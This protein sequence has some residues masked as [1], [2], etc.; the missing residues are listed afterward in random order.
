MIVGN[1]QSSDTHAYCEQEEGIKKDQMKKIY[2]GLL[3]LLIIGAIGFIGCR[4]E[5]A[6]QAAA[7]AV[8]VT[9]EALAK[10]AG[11]IAFN[12]GSNRFD[13]VYL[14]YTY[15]DKRKK[16]EIITQSDRLL[17]RLRKEPENPSLQQELAEF[18]HFKDMTALKEHTQAII[19]NI[20]KM[21]SR[22]G[23]RNTFLSP[24]G[25]RLFY[26]ARTLYAG[27][28]LKEAKTKTNGIW[29]EFVEGNLSSFDYYDYVN[30]EGLEAFDEQGGSSCS[31]VCCWE[32]LSCEANAHSNFIRNSWAYALGG[33]GAMATG[34]AAAGSGVP[35]I[36]T[37]A[38]GLV[39]G[40]WGASMGL[41]AANTIYKNDLYTCK[42]NYIICL[43]KKNK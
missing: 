35:G 6:H 7:G 13:P 2:S 8:T 4:K 33:A 28:K 41:V 11:F 12:E 18:Y 9:A 3:T 1:Y 16:E 15:K 19:E 36:G 38:G 20:K 22:Y 14:I 17:S 42:V 29:L 23:Y 10:D 30:A 32:R 21:D 39:G 25:G 24:E 27:N 31:E 5:S 43:L 37:V 26:R 34:G 40:L